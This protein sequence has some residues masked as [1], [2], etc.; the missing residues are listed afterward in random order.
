MGNLE[1]YRRRLTESETRLRLA[2]AGG[3]ARVGELALLRRTTEIMR[4]ELTSAPGSVLVWDRMGPDPKSG[5]TGADRWAQSCLEKADKELHP[6]YAPPERVAQKYEEYLNL[7]LEMLR[8]GQVRQELIVDKQEGRQYL[9]LGANPLVLA[10]MKLLSAELMQWARAQP[11]TREF[12]NAPARA[13]LAR[14][15]TE[16]PDLATLLRTADTLPLDVEVSEVP[17]Q[18][19]AMVEAV[20]FA[21]GLVPVV[22]S[23]VA[24]YEAWS[25]V[26]LF[27]Y[28]LTDLERGVLAASVLLPL[29]GR[30][31]KGGRALY[32]EARLVSMYGRDAASWSR[33]VASGG[34]AA[35][36][37]EAFVAI[38]RAEEAL[39]VDR[40]LT[41]AVATDAAAAVPRLTKDPGRLATVLD[42]AVLDLWRELSSTHAPLRSL[43]ELALER[44]LAKGP[45]VDHLKGQVLEELIESR[46]VPWLSTREGG[47]ALGITVPAGKKVE[48]LPGHLIR[49]AAGRQLTDGMLVYRDKG[50]LVIAAVFEAKAGANA[51]RELSIKRASLS[52]LT[53]AERA[54]LR[55][56]AKDVW[57][58]QRDAA[59]LAGRRFTKTVEDVEKEYALSELGGQVRRDVER[60][61]DGAT[62]S[63]GGQASKVRISPTRTKFFGVLPR[64]VRASTIEK[65]LKDAGFM[66]EIL[67]VDLRSSELK[68]IAAKLQPLADKLAQAPP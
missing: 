59:R 25:G 53:D 37:Q 61:A 64:D 13:G 43:D 50:E 66:Y 42:P 12:I 15:L 44:I 23:V 3:I 36:E 8:W 54:E 55:A 30:L 21:I 65:Q 32:T 22:G 26:D 11:N 52:T 63:V 40:S 20:E 34:R 28:R 45:N 58:E 49:D 51:A 57:R 19:P 68:D 16:R 1:S 6:Q 5:L 39:R 35:A 9:V 41:R 17:V 27:N 18:R 48:F 31:V 56:N 62:V 67:G 46:L 60:L 38:R 7:S 33:A 29:A 14:L 2:L 24:A 10:I 4:D 47:F